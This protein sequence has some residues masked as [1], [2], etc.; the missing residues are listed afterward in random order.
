MILS[1]VLCRENS[2]R[3]AKCYRENDNTVVTETMS[4]I[5]GIH[6]KQKLVN[7]LGSL[8]KKAR[9][10]GQFYMLP[11]SSTWFLVFKLIT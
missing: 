5:L 8:L 10:V 2:K 4:E 3:K 11:D 7:G 6:F 9:K 1:I